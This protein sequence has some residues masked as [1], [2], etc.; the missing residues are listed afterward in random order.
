M[1]RFK[2][3][4]K[5]LPIKKL[6][7]KEYSDS[8]EGCS[9][10]LDDIYK[11][12][13][14]AQNKAESLHKEINWLENIGKFISYEITD[15]TKINPAFFPLIETNL[16]FEGYKIK[17]GSKWEKIN[18]LLV[19]TRKEKKQKIKDV[20][21]D[22]WLNVNGMYPNYEN[23]GAIAINSINTNDL[24]PL[25]LNKKTKLK[26]SLHDYSAEIANV[27]VILEK[28]AS[29]QNL[30]L[31]LLEKRAIKFIAGEIIANA[32]QHA[33]D[34]DGSCSIGIF[35]S[36]KNKKII[37]TIN[38]TGMSIPTS[39]RN[40]NKN[41]KN[42]KLI[43]DFEAIQWALEKGNT[44][45]S[46]K[47]Q[48]GIGLYRV[49]KIIEDAKGEFA[50]RSL[51]GIYHFKNGKIKKNINYYKNFGTLFY[52]EFFLRNLTSKSLNISKE[53][54]EEIKGVFIN[55]K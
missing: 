12:Y 2:K 51:S 23:K 40:H 14:N 53:T 27:L 15:K 25:Y 45:K 24:T 6:I 21:G 28:F 11:H 34:E 38:D 44:T 7:F 36:K 26:K 55:E 42:K 19:E 9:K 20:K 33:F 16:N 4:F 22:E 1:N 30:K 5:T 3:N 52:A 41:K 18:N 46:K 39:V 54:W 13:V 48:G 8:W 37:M 31:N 47:L 49:K 17:R 32:F 29:S 35:L 10:L 50:F 43:K